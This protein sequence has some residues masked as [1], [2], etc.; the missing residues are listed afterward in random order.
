MSTVEDLEEDLDEV[1][2]LCSRC[3]MTQGDGERT[4]LTQK[5]HELSEGVVRGGP[6]ELVEPSALVDDLGQS[7]VRAECQSS[8]VSSHLLDSLSKYAARASTSAERLISP[9]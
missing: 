4:R 7:C 5:L 8:S 1:L 2:K 9:N 6:L 3:Y